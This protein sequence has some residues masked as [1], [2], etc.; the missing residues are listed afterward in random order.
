[1]RFFGILFLL[2]IGSYGCTHLE[3]PSSRR[4]IFIDGGAHVGES[5]L[6]FEQSKLYPEHSWE[7]FSFEANPEMIP[8]LTENLRLIPNK[9][10]VTVINKAMW[11][12]DKGIDFFFGVTDLAGNVVKTRDS[13]TTRKP[14]HIDSV[15][16]GQW[17]KKNF[18][19]K[20]FIL[21]KMDIEGAEYPILRKMLKDGSIKYVDKLYVEFHPS[22]AENES[23]S[24]DEEI[25]AAIKK[26]G[27]PVAVKSMTSAQ[28]SY[29]RE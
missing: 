12:D 14:V 29:F 24:K 18:T 17:L 25:V 8:Y 13:D 15:D 28:G 1:M 2:A 4:Y 27:I 22:I 7:I 6:D 20:D 10:N 19:Q 3:N 26:L 21:V 16:F 11:I 9:P 5:V 23:E